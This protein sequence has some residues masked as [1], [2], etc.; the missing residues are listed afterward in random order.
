MLTDLSL[1]FGD[2]IILFLLS[3]F[4]ELI[5]NTFP[6]RS[7]ACKLTLLNFLHI[8]LMWPFILQ[9]WQT[10]FFTLQF[11]ELWFLITQCWH[12]F[13]NVTF[14]FILML[15]R[16][17]RSTLQTFSVVDYSNSAASFVDNSMAIVTL[18][19]RC[20]VRSV[21]HRRLL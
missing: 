16:F 17:H 3:L 20:K 9:W 5:T 18:R 2:I 15:G 8:D 6:S 12:V 14:S 7:F 19:D 1:I 21:I 10:A 11:S 4:K 13:V